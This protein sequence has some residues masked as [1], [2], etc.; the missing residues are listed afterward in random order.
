MLV[1][2]G[3]L[4]RPGRMALQVTEVTDSAYVGSESAYSECETFTDED[5]G[6]LATQEDPE[7]EGDGGVSRI[8]PPA[9]PEGLEISL[10]DISVISV[11]GQEEQFEDFGEGTEPDLFSSQCDE[12]QN[13]NQTTSS[14]QPLYSSGGPV[15]ERQLLA[16]PPCT[17]IGGLFC[18]QC[19]KHVNRLEDL[20]TRLRYLEMDSPDKRPS[21]RKEA[22]RLH[23][24]SLLVEDSM[25]RQLADMSCDETDLTDKVLYLEQR[26]S[27]LERDASTNG[28]QQN[29]LR[30]ENLQLLHR[31]HALEEQLK[32]QELRSD[33]VQGE[34][35]RRHREE[36]RKMERDCGYELSSLKAR[37]QELESEN[38]ELRSQVPVLKATTQ[39]LEE[40]NQKLRD[41]VEEVRRQLKENKELNQ[42]LGGRLNKEKHKQQSEKEQSQEVIEE[43]RRE[44]EQMQLMRLEM[45]HRLG[46]GNTSALQEYNSRAREAELEHEVRRLKQEQRA[47]KEQNEE[48]NGQIINLSIQGAKNLFSTTFS[49]SLAAEISSVSRDELMEAIQK[50]EEINL[51]LQDYI[52]RIIVAIMETN[53]AILEVKMQ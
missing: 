33:Q 18:S 47:L 7:T 28:E 39:R 49:D 1:Q 34:E 17:A 32:E 12:D 27:E 22:R 3:Q 16:P 2:G 6:A 11:T 48:L 26:V 5:T 20:S 29:R 45:E 53:P 25:E 21:S 37:V 36:L 23:H 44:L 24:S 4:L 30:Q 13:D 50:Q 52:D 31:A 40:E 14:I 38:L 42:K 19:H 41:Q 10:C 8:P 43:L 9:T 46:L 15:S 35:T 51:R